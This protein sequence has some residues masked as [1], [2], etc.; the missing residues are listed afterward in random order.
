MKKLLP[1]LL[2]SVLASGALAQTNE[3]A[4]FLSKFE[5]TFE[6]PGMLPT[7][8]FVPEAQLSGRLHQVRPLASNDGLLNTY[9]LD[10][11]SGVQEITGTPALLERIREIYAIEYL[12]GLSSSDE[13]RKALE[14]AGKAK[15]E[16][17]VGIVSDPIGTIKSVPKGA[18][19]FFGRI[20][21]GLKTVGKN[22]EGGGGKAIAGIL[23]VTKEKARLATKLNVSPYSTNEELQR[24]LTKAAQASAGGG[25]VI[26]VAA[27]FASGGAGVALTVAGV[28]ETLTETLV[29]STP[30]DLRIINRKKLVALGVDR[31]L[32]DEFLMHPWFSPWSQTIITDSLAK[33]GV[34]PFD[35]LT[36]AVKAL[37]PEDAFYFLRLSQI[38]AT[39]HTTTAPIQSIQLRN[40]IIAARDRD[41][42]L[43]V[44]VS[45]DYAIWAERAA[46]RAEEFASL[47]RAANGLTGLTLWTD[48]RLSERLSEE[49]KK[50]GITFRT[51]VLA[52]K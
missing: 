45:C 37:T 4:A 42:V 11:P 5:S 3:D 2:L 36:F 44:P 34:N 38:L 49:L 51:E 46:R 7:K 18:S 50:R 12:R 35:F 10:T 31:E 26:N 13:F 41:G 21:E 20:G 15:L 6:A 40:R 48:G 19:R 16:S 22:D 14:K 29:N 52:K 8:D 47:D 39:Y 30:E 43:V 24:E 1:V 17:A 28:N 25:L 9:F 23:G 32:A 27:S 33:I